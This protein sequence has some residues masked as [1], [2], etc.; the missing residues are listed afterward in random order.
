MEPQILK[1]DGDSTTKVSTLEWHG[2]AR[3]V[4]SYL[5]GDGNRTRRLPRRFEV[6]ALST[7]FLPPV[8]RHLLCI[9]SNFVG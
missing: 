6:A 4:S 8:S 2:S 7:K 9:L 5:G 1:V 3:W